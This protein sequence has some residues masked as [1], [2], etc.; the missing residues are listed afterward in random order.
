VE[1]CVSSAPTTF[2]SSSST[3]AMPQISTAGRQFPFGDQFSQPERLVYLDI[4]QNPFNQWPS[5][6]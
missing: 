4:Q 1:P 3:N 6:S 5:W 2:T